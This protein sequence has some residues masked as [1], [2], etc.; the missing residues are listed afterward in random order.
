TIPAPAFP[1]DDAPSATQNAAQAQTPATVYEDSTVRPTQS[2]SRTASS[3]TATTTPIT[4]ATVRKLGRFELVYDDRGRAHKTFQAVLPHGGGPLRRRKNDDGRIEVE[5]EQA[6]IRY[7]HSQAVRTYG[8]TSTP[9]PATNSPINDA[10]VTVPQVTGK[11]T[12]AGSQSLPGP[13]LAPLPTLSSSAPL[14][15]Y[16]SGV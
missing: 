15:R 6:T 7:Q 11:D 12:V 9:T 10:A 13:A 8:S 3:F 16:P 1:T 2:G 5:L 4:E 14:E